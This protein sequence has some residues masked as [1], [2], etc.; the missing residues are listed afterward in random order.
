[1]FGHKFKMRQSSLNKGW[2]VFYCSGND[3]Q[4]CLQQRW[5]FHL[6]IFHLG[7]TNNTQ[8]LISLL[9]PLGWLEGIGNDAL[10][11]DKE[12]LLDFP[13][14]CSWGQLPS[15][16]VVWPQGLAKQKME[17]TTFSMLETPTS[18]H[19]LAKFI[20]STGVQPEEKQT[21]L[22]S[23]G[24]HQSQRSCGRRGCLLWRAGNEGWS[25]ILIHNNDKSHKEFGVSKPKSLNWYL[26]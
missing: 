26:I 6:A 7:N 23:A 15:A 18:E 5:A 2:F 25:Q 14:W 9:G 24:P 3:R 10:P 4:I 1:M 20:C 12:M 17:R 13:S 16:N 22:P 21:A 8:H 11:G 19:I